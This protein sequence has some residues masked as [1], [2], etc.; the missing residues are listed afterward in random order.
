M[1]DGA[2][3]AVEWRDVAAAT[4]DGVGVLDGGEF[5]HADAALADCYGFDDPAALRGRSWRALFE[6]GA[7]PRG[8]GY[9]LGGPRD[10]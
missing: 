3:T 7:R 4:T 8:V 10:R 1:S 9:P 2:N 5:V 6:A